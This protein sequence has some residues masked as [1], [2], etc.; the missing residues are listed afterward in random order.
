MYLLNLVRKNSP[1]IKYKQQP[2]TEESNEEKQQQQQQN[3][4]N[5][6]GYIYIFIVQHIE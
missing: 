4:L 3:K 1:T 6:N 5:T 2:N